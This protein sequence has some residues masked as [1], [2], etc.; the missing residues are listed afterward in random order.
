MSMKLLSSENLYIFGIEEFLNEEIL[1]KIA[2][3]I[4][5][6]EDEFGTICD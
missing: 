4:A 5:C 2:V 1:M 3:K 6:H